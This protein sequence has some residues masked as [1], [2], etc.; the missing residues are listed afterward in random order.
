MI[1]GLMSNSDSILETSNRGRSNTSVLW[2]SL[3]ACLSSFPSPLSLSPHSVSVLFP[4]RSC[5]FLINTAAKSDSPANFLEWYLDP[6][7]YLF[8]G[9]QCSPGFNMI[10]MSSQTSVQFIC[11]ES[12]RTKQSWWE[13]L[14]AQTGL[15]ISHLSP[16][17]LFLSLILKFAFSQT[18]YITIHGL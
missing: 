7:Y 12:V 15:L 16:M 5:P 3:T 10:N 13:M 6:D 4:T 2:I 8:Q 1:S 9:C 17:T 11:M 14:N 18:G